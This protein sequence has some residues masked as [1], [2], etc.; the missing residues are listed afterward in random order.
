MPPPYLASKRMLP[1]GAFGSGR[2]IVEGGPA[3]LTGGAQ[4]F[5]GQSEIER[6]KT[7]MP[8]SLASTGGIGVTHRRTYCRFQ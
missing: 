7:P 8:S 2:A 6:G 3:G 1:G 4:T 5:N